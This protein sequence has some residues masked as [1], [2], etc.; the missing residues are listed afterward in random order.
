MLCSIDLGLAVDQAS[1]AKA[2]LDKTR[3]CHNPPEVYV[4]NSDVFRVLDFLITVAISK[5]L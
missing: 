1:E 2:F 5:A 4:S 3:A